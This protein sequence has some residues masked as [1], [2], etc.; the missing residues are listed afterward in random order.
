[1]KKAIIL[2]NAFT[3]SEGELN[4]PKRMKEELAK[5][6]VEAH[7]M[8][9]SP[10]ALEAE[11]DFCIFLDKDKYAARAIE[12]R[13]RLFNRAEAIE[14]CD[15][16]MLTFLALD[17]VPQPETISSRLCYSADAPVDGQF[18]DEAESRLGYPMVVKENHGSLGRQV[19]LARDRAE[20]CSL[21]TRLQYVPH[22]YQK[23]IAESSGRD[24]RVICVGGEAVA[25]MKRENERDFR[26]NLSAGGRG[27]PFP[28]DGEIRRLA[29]LVS[30]CLKLDYCGIDLLLSHDGYLVCE[31]NSNAF[32]GGI[33]NVTGINVAASYAC[34]ILNEIR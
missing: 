19:Y 18:L 33:E 17:C 5:L 14:T 13:M 9:N 4:Q 28:V 15:D 16:K 20:L 1:M 25:C 31:V 23:F 10:A 11:A 26:S 27:E 12:K 34:Y 24:V 8:R 6:G 30:T 2:I 22:L 3:Q 21:A 29:S 32:F 7:I